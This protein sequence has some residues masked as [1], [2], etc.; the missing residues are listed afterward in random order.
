MKRSECVELQEHLNEMTSKCDKLL[1]DIQVSNDSQMIQQQEIRLVYCLQ[2]LLHKYTGFHSDLKIQ[3][4]E[5]EQQISSKTE[6]ANEMSSLLAQRAYR[7]E[8][9]ENLLASL[10]ASGNQVSE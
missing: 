3:L 9:L 2:L 1:S 4:T 6:L 8:E 10:D 5:L 7:I